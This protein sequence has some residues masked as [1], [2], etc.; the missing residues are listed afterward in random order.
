MLNGLYKVGFKTQLGE[1]FGVVVLKDGVVSGG[2]SSMYYTGSYTDNDGSFVAEVRADTHTK[3]SGIAPVFGV[4]PVNIKLEGSISSA[5]P[6]SA[7]A[8]DLVGTSPD[9]PGIKFAAKM[10][11]LTD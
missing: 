2:D 8:I 3:I 7:N 9:A 1:G 6:K 4:S 10:T 11:R 5:G